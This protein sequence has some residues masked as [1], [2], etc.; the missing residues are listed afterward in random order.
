MEVYANMRKDIG[1]LIVVSYNEKAERIERKIYI[2]ET[3]D[4]HINLVIKGENGLPKKLPD[5]VFWW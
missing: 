1:E 2:E 5:T 4:G 3:K